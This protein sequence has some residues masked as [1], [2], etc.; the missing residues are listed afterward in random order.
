MDPSKSHPLNDK[1]TLWY[2]PRGRHVLHCATD[3]YLQNL[4]NLGFCPFF[5]NKETLNYRRI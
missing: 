3:K 1:W 5:F 4:H 2:A